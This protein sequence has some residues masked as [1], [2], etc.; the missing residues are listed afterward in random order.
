MAKEPSLAVLEPGHK[1]AR[2][3]R[4]QRL[5]DVQSQLDA[6]LVLPHFFWLP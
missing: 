2:L 1:I 5:H 3:R 6:A 4:P